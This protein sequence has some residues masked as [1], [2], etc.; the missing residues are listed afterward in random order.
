MYR[1]FPA[2]VNRPG[3]RGGRW[4]KSARHSGGV[5]GELPVVVCLSLCRRD[6]AD[7]FEQA[8]V[9]EPGHHSSVANSTA[10]LVFQGARR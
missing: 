5:T 3:I 1:S 9:V 7:G 4:F 6:V 10:S 2:V 8:L